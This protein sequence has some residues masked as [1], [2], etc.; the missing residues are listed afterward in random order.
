MVLGV[1]TACSIV[2]IEIMLNLRIVCK[3]G[4]N[5]MHIVR[6]YFRVNEVCIRLNLWS[7]NCKA[8]EFKIPAG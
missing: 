6:R 2:K 4:S 3:S 8:L 7:K 1:K 5:K